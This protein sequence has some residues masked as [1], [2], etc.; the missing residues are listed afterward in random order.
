MS[1]PRRAETFLIPLSFGILVYDAAGGRFRTFRPFHDDRYTPRFLHMMQLL[2]GRHV[3]WADAQWFLRM[4]AD[5][6]A[7]DANGI[8][9]LDCAFHAGPKGSY[10]EGLI[11][12]LMKKGANVRARPTFLHWAALGCRK[13]FVTYAIENGA[14]VNARDV[15]GKTPLHWAAGAQGDYPRSECS[16]REI[17][18]IL[19][20][21]GADVNARDMAGGTPLD[22]AM[23][24][25]YPESRHGSGEDGAAIADLLRR[26][27]GK[28][29]EELK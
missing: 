4:G 11:W 3:G 1:I 5:V 22:H 13:S 27:G 12:F 25:S 29:G 17:L 14:D 9:P 16:H 8:T 18:E 26:H 6:N 19:I 23:G 2:S 24:H 28:S 7:R 21:N 15:L 20:A 10:D